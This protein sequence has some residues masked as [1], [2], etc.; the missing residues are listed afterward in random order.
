MYS[1]LGGCKET[2]VCEHLTIAFTERMY[3]LLSV[4]FK[5]NFIGKPF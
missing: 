4:A 2:L 1:L 5:I 3:A